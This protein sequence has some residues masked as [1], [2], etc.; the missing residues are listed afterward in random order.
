M[1]YVMTVAQNGVMI[2]EQGNCRNVWV[3]NSVDEFSKWLK[4]R[5]PKSKGAT[6]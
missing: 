5:I 2:T 4:E 6:T 1:K 3:F